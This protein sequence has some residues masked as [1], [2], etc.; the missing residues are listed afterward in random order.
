LPSV[1]Y[2]TNR[3]VHVVLGTSRGAPVFASSQTLAEAAFEPLVESLETLAAVVMPDHVHWLLADGTRLSD[4]VGRYKSHVAACARRL[5]IPE[6]V[7][8]RSFWD[9]VVRSSEKLDV[10]A[11]YVVENPIRAGLFQRWDDCP[12]VVFYA[13]RIADIQ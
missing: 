11:R 8:Q 9:H 12:F 3:P 5:G 2:E 6:R 7:W 13:D 10:I 1:A 4:T